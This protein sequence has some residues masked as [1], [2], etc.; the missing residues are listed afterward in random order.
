MDYVGSVL[1]I[2]EATLG[3]MNLRESHKYKDEFI[4]LRQAHYDESNKNEDDQDFA[5]MDRIEYRLKL[6]CVSVASDINKSDI[7]NKP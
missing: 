5:V 4:S 6:L 3:Y 1:K 2:I 7:E